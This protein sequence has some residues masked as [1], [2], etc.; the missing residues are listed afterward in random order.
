[1]PPFFNFKGNSK[2]ADAENA[3]ERY[4]GTI[5]AEAAENMQEETHM[6]VR[7][8]FCHQVQF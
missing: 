4:T 6:H 8:I 2:H 5:E 7:Q 3:P 1:M